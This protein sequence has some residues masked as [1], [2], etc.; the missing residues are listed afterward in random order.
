MDS[1]HV[2]LRAETSSN[3][4]LVCDNDGLDAVVV[5]HSDGISNSGK[6]PHL[7]HAIEPVDV[8]NDNAISI[9]KDSNIFFGHV[10]SQPACTWRTTPACRMRRPASLKK[11]LV[12][13]RQPTQER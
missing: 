10:R 13:P 9:Q 1:P 6:Q 11:S 12:S 7:V 8:L 5:E 2:L 3:N 4:R